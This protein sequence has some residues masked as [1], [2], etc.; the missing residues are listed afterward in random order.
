MLDDGA[1]SDFIGRPINAFFASEYAEIL[2][3]AFD[4]LCR[5]ADAIPFKMITEGG[6]I[7]S[8]EIQA[9]WARGLGPDT[10]IITATDITG[11]VKMFEDIQRSEARYRKL[12]QQAQNM[13]C[14]V[15]D[16]RISFINEAGLKLLK[17]NKAEDIVGINLHDLFQS[18][19]QDIV[20]NNIQQVIDENIPLL[21]KMDCLDDGALDIKMTLAPIEKSPSFVYMAEIQ[22]VTDHNKAAKDLHQTN[23][24]LA[25]RAIELLEA[26]EAAEMANRVKVDF[27][28]NMSHE[29]RTPLNAIIGFSELIQAEAMGPIEIQQYL[30]FAAEI[31]ESGAHLLQ[32]VSDVLDVTKIEKGDLEPH[33]E[34]TNVVEIIESAVNKMKARADNAK[35]RLEFDSDSKPV[36]ILAD[37]VYFQQILLNLLSNS[38]KFS[39]A[40]SRVEILTYQNTQNGLVLKVV[41]QGIGIENDIVQAILEPFSRVTT[42]PLDGTYEGTGLGLSI[43]NALVEAHEAIL[44]IESIPGTGTTVTVTFPP[45]LTLEN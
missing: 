10:K 2:D 39:N 35:I 43:V 37:P 18:E 14:V 17:V 31:N 41:D 36:T 5:E 33:P 26:K 40:G 24:V 9:F 45:E 29:L 19:Y 13:I 27:L 3:R 30:Q 38:I 4:D 12:V 7:I 20:E 25:I 8:T 42:S 22:N 32:V 16:K 28:A 15:T 6:S 1:S 34:K 21:A 11:R 23:Q 44:D